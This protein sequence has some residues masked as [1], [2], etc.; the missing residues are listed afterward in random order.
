MLLKAAEV[1]ITGYGVSDRGISCGFSTLR[2]EVITG[3]SR[4][5][6]HATSPKSPTIKLKKHDTDPFYRE[7]SRSV[8]KV[9]KQHVHSKSDV[10][11]AGFHIFQ[12]HTMPTIF[13]RKERLLA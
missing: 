1:R 5:I 13:T 7:I 6:S 9:Q 11:M 8:N 4:L 12:Q 2:H 3:K 10:N